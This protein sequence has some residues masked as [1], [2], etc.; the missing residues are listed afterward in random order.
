MKKSQHTA[1]YKRL[2]AALKAAREKAELTQEQAAER[3]GTY[4]TFFS[5]V[6][7]HERRIDVV[8]LVQICKVFGVDP[9]QVMRD[10]KLLD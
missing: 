2:V 5:K 10:A 3:L 6:E 4:P 8:E 9:I 7:T 1:A